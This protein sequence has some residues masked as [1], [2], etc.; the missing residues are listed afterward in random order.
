[1]KYTTSQREYKQTVCFGFWERAEANANSDV[2]TNTSRGRRG[3]ATCR[4]ACRITR[5]AVLRV[6][7]CW[8]PAC[9]RLQR[10]RRPKGVRRRIP[11]LRNRQASF[12]VRICAR[13]HARTMSPSEHTTAIAAPTRMWPQAFA[14]LRAWNRRDNALGF[15]KASLAPPSR[16][17]RLNR[18]HSRTGFNSLKRRQFSASADPEMKRLGQCEDHQLFAGGRADVVMHAQ[19]VDARGL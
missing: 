19:H 16:A 17:S 2:S 4:S 3:H 10:R 9:G 12:P 8:G 1:M 11:S 18:T 13:P 6:T 7:A 14:A 5:P 15:K